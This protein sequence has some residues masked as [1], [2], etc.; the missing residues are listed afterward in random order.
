MAFFTDDVST[1]S[2]RAVVDQRLVES[3]VSL[4]VSPTTFSLSPDAAAALRAAAARVVAQGPV[5][6]DAANATTHARL[7]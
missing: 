4:G 2:L 7:Q 5:G 1:S 6:V 3:L